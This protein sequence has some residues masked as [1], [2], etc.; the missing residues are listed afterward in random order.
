MEERYDGA[1]CFILASEK[2]NLGFAKAKPNQLQILGKT[3]SVEIIRIPIDVN[4]T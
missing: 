3:K 1:N 4:C 2:S